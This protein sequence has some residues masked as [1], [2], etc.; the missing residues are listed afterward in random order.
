[1]NPKLEKGEALERL[2][3]IQNSGLDHNGAGGASA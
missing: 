3:E 2:T 1:M